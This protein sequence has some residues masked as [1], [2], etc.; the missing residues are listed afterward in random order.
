MNWFFFAKAVLIHAAEPNLR[1][2][3]TSDCYR[4]ST[5]P[6]LRALSTSDCYRNSAE[7]NL[8]ALSASDCYRNSAEPGRETKGQFTGT[9]YLGLLP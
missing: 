3:S 9:I 8:R 4:N 1:A 6:N 2:L 7:P 5:E